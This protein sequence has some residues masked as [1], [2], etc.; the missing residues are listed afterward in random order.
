MK[1]GDIWWANLPA[2]AGR[3]PVV[4]LSRNAAYERRQLITVAPVTSRGRGIRSEVV[5]D[6]QDGLKKKSFAN[7][8]TI[9]T[10][11]K[12]VLEERISSLSS[13]KLWEVEEAIRFALGLRSNNVRLG[14]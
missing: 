1:R 13:Q 3:R 9:A 7:F 11:P 12:A 4:L 5:L 10:I 8:D 6:R 14:G 2:P